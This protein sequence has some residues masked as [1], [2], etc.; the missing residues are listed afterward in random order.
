MSRGMP[1]ACLTHTKGELTK[2]VLQ[3]K[4][5]RMVLAKD[6]ED[7]GSIEKSVNAL[8]WPIEGRL[9]ALLRQ[10]SWMNY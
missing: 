2:L 5:G 10:R 7:V 9:Y 4:E 3:L 1:R 8:V 6:P